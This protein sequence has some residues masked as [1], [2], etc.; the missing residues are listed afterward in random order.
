MPH[1]P[2]PY[3]Q[4]PG[5]RLSRCESLPRHSC[6]PWGELLN[7]SGSVSLFIEC[8][9]CKAVKDYVRGC[10]SLSP[11]PGHSRSCA[12]VNYIDDNVNEVDGDDDNDGDND[13]FRFIY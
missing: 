8:L 12:Q 7:V 3:S 11:A 1:V 9:P 5:E 4:A 10:M 13:G 6:V 2:L